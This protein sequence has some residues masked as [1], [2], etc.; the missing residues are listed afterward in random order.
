MICK[1]CGGSMYMDD[2][3]SWGKGQIAKYYHCGYCEADCDV[4]LGSK[5]VVIKER[6]TNPNKN[7]YKIFKEV[8]LNQLY[9]IAESNEQVKNIVELIKK[10]DTADEIIEIIK[11]TNLSLT[12]KEVELI[13]LGIK[14]LINNNQNFG[15]V[16]KRNFA[17]IVDSKQHPFFI[18][19]SIINYANTHDLSK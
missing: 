18:Y 9:A 11:S 4:I 5:N 6:W 15:D 2:A 13:K 8:L 14:E 12:E 19:V 10:V 7:N 3:G 1:F 17:N 16:T